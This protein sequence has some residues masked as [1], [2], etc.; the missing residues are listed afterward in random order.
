MLART[1]QLTFRSQRKVSW[2]NTHVRK[3]GKTG[4]RNILCKSAQGH[5]VLPVVRMLLCRPVLLPFFSAVQ[6]A[7]GCLGVN[8]LFPRWLYLRANGVRTLDLTQ[9]LSPQGTLVS[10]FHPL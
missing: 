10:N 1:A 5:L 7:C 2:I 3:S 6:A 4:F 8:V 9:L